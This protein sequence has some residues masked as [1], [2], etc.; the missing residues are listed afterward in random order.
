MQLTVIS[1]FDMMFYIPV[2]PS[3]FTVLLGNEY[4]VPTA[5]N[6]YL[7]IYLMYVS[8]LEYLNQNLFHVSQSLS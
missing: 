5:E 6:P 1:Y 2:L 4:K 8:Y 3:D 7:Q